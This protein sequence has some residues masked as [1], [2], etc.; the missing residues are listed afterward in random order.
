MP[1]RLLT[2]SDVCERLQIG[3]TALHFGSR[4]GTFPPPIKIGRASRWR[5]SDIDKWIARQPTT[6]PGP[7][8]DSTPAAPERTAS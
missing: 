3:R 8:G 1:E 2:T 6:A 7:D 5:E 4:D